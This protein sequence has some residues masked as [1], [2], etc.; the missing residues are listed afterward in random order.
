MNYSI[1]VYR[2]YDTDKLSRDVEGYINAN[3]DSDSIVDIRYSMLEDS[4]TFILH[5]VLIII[6]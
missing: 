6:K 3:T 5:S 1:K 2:N 4:S